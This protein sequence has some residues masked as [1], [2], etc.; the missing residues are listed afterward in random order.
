MN[1]LK[2]IDGKR[3]SVNTRE[4]YLNLL[5]TV[6]KF[7]IKRGQIPATYNPVAN[8]NPPGKKK[9]EEP[10]TLSVE[11]VKHIFAFVK[12]TP[13]YHKFIPVLAVGF[14]CGA[15]VDERAKITYRDI[16]VGGRNEIYISA[17]NAKN[18]EARYI[19]PSENFRSWMDFAK[20]HGVT[21]HPTEYLLTGNSVKQRRDAHSSFLRTLTRETGIKLPKNCIRHTAASFMAERHGYTSTANQLGHDIATLLKHY[22]RAITKTEAEDYYNITPDSV[23]G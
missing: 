2:G 3:A 6:F 7:C 23:C 9:I 10:E 13:R 1:S 8:L 5:K 19:Y 15:R 12:N 4:Q 20:A 17:A 21:M 11:E 16:F 22:R 14:F 18:G